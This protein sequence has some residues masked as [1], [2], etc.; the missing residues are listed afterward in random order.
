MVYRPI[1]PAVDHFKKPTMNKKV[2]LSA[3]DIERIHQ[4]A[5]ML[6]AKLTHPWTIP[7]IA[8][9]VKLTEKKVKAGFKQEFGIGPHTYLRNLRIEKA[10]E[11][12]ILGKPTQAI[13]WATGFK[14]ESGLS[15]TFK[16]VVKVTPTEFR[17]NPRLW[18]RDPAK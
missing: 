15:K 12:F 18:N 3:L 6:A 10:K 9:A 16:K 14:S 5:G 4:A 7:N 2:H 17:N 1:W 8:E 13:L 11:L